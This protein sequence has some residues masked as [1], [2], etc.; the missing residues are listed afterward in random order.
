[1]TI[2]QRLERWVAERPD[3]LAYQFYGADRNDVHSLSF[4]GLD[5]AA[6]R[7]SH[8][9]RVRTAPGDRVLIIAPS[10]VEYLAALFG[11]LLAGRLAVTLSPPRKRSG[12]DAQMQR[13]AAVAADCAPA[14]VATTRASAALLA[15]DVGEPLFGLPMIF[16]DDLPEEAD[17][18]ATPGEDTAFLQYT[19]GSTRTPRGVMVTHANLAANLELCARVFRVGPD[20]VMCGWL[21]LFHDMG[22][23]GL[24]LQAVHSGCPYHFSSPTTFLARPLGWLERLSET[25]ATCTGAP[26]FAFDLCADRAGEA[27]DDLDLSRLDMLFCGAEPIRLPAL[28]R[29]AAA[30]ARHGLSRKV[31]APGYGL[32]EA[33]LVVSLDTGA[34][35]P[36]ARRGPDAKHAPFVD[37][38]AVQPEFR[39]ALVDPARRSPVAEGQIGELWLAGPC[40][41]PGYWQAPEATA[42]VFGAHLADGSGPWMRTGDLAFLTGDRLHIAGRVKDVIIIAGQN[43]LPQDIEASAVEACPSIDAGGACAF[44]VAGPRGPA[45][46]V[47]AEVRRAARRA[48]LDA[49]AA[50]VATTVTQV[51]GVPVHDVVILGPR[52]LPRTT[53]GKL[54]R[55]ACREAYEQGALAALARLRAAGL[56]RLPV[57]VPDLAQRLRARVAELCGRPESAVDLRDGPAR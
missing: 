21:P 53:S 4:A 36:A 19:S 8:A 45:V 54:Q 55:S 47:A 5:L 2:L 20:S 18:A 7:A 29:F 56:A 39:S 33:T 34:Q 57:A 38:G 40:V 37:C 1:V 43:H 46:V 51:H 24:A 35:G 10:G 14:L 49:L 48:D 28:E 12:A 52:R 42:D 27:P 31:I 15:N 3:A 9:I 22:L 44:E 13:I 25:G 6:R 41:A 32:A 23:I 16:A 26:N 50:D 11:C 30:F 17:R